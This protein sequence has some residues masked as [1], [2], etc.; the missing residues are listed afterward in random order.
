LFPG[1]LRG[2]AVAVAS[3]PARSSGLSSAIFAL[4]RC[5]IVPR[6]RAPRRAF[7]TVLRSAKVS[8][9]NAPGEHFV[10]R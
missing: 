2:Q 9:A 4:T 5:P 3:L 6:T 10:Y 1:P 8:P 7:R